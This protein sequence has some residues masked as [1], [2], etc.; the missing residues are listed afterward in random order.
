ML[1]TWKCLCSKHRARSRSAAESPLHDEVPVLWAPKCAVADKALCVTSLNNRPSVIFVQNYH[2]NTNFSSKYAI[3]ITPWTPKSQEK[4][5]VTPLSGP[6]SCCLPAKRIRALGRTLAAFLQLHQGR[7]LRLAASE[8][9]GAQRGDPSP[10]SSTPG[11]LP[12]LPRLKTRATAPS[13]QHR[14][15]PR[16]HF[17]A[18]LSQKRGMHALTAR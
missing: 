5:D 15:P 2:L 13:R 6:T 8:Q 11:A 16:G 1:V 10:C 18:R 17:S 3:K 14:S 7:G 4:V 9:R 12:G